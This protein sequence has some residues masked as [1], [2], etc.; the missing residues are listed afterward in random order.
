MEKCKESL[1]LI[2]CKNKTKQNN[3]A[4]QNPDYYIHYWSPIREER[5]KKCIYLI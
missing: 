2:Q 4:K 1:K 3:K 5:E